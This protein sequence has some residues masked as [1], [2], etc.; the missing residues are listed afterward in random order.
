MQVEVDASGKVKRKQQQDMA[1]VFANGKQWSILIPRK[2]KDQAHQA[3]QRH[4]RGKRNVEVRV[5]LLSIFVYLLLRDHIIALTKITIDREYPA[6]ENII[7][8]HILNLFRCQGV[9]VERDKITVGKVKP[10]SA[11]DKLAWRVSHHL[12][13][14]DRVLTLGDIIA[15]F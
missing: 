8:D 10:G 1:V 3:Y 11:A 2:V 14:P 7:R 15:E 13:T 4:K 12:V 5:L 6:H 9:T